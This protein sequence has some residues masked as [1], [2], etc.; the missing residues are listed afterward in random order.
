[1]NC[2]SSSESAIEI[3]G[4]MVVLEAGQSILIQGGPESHCNPSTEECE[5]LAI[6]LATFP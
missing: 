3:D 6:C 1:M 5:Y 4:E 2:L